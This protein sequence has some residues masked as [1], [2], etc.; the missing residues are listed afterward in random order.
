[1]IMM[2]LIILGPQGSG[3][4]TQ[5]DLIAKKTGIAHISTGDM[6]RANVK[7]GTELG[8]IAEECMNKGQL[9]PN[10]IT[11]DMLKE[12]LNQE[13]A[14][15]GFVLDGFPRNIEQAN[16]L[17][18]ITKI[19]KVVEVKVSNRESIRRIAGRR[20]CKCGAVY[21]TFY[22]PPNILDICDKCDSNLVQRDDD[23]EDVIRKRLDIYHSQTAPLIDHYKDKH[24]AINGEQ[25]IEKVF[26]DI[27]KELKLS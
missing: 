1:V 11:V 26:E 10:D 2:N 6:L 15:K 27:C 21:H 3:K 16:A 5:A 19:D 9:V 24:I 7:E 4:G 25:T 23:K 17:D 22:N 20:T 12:R 8:K 13:D 14:K 18:K